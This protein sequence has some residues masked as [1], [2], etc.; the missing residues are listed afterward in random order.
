MD[1]FSPVRF[2]KN[3]EKFWGKKSKAGVAQV[4]E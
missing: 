3:W 2:E 1:E 4:N